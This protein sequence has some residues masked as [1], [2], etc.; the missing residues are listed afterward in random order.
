L[1]RNPA[2]G[3]EDNIVEQFLRRKIDFTRFIAK[4]DQA[5]A[6]LIRLGLER[7]QMIVPGNVG[8]DSRANA[9]V[10]VNC[11]HHSTRQGFFI[12]SL[13]QPR[14]RCGSGLS[15]QHE[16]DTHEQASLPENPSHFLPLLRPARVTA[17]GNERPN[18]RGETFNRLGGFSHTAST[19]AKQHMTDTEAPV[20]ADVL[21]NL[22]R[23]ANQW[24][25]RVGFLIEDLYR[26]QERDLNAFRV[27]AEALGYALKFL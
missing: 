4:P 20:G 6:Q 5:G 7:A 24:T 13:Y 19:E 3:L 15:E 12:R 2:S 10:S 9:G 14:E 22:L 27:T 17:L 23:G 16:S 8:V 26:A 21:S 18:L 1:F 11:G 25:A